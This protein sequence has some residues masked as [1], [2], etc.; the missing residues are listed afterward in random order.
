MN[1]Y[2]S[3]HCGMIQM[4]KKLQESYHFVDSMLPKCA[5]VLEIKLPGRCLAEMFSGK[6]HSQ[7]SGLREGRFRF[8]PVGNLAKIRHGS[9][10]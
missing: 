8:F 3:Q 6:H 1:P 10:A 5:S 9:P 4:H 7:P 2:H